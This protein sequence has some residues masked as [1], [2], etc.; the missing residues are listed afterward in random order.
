MSDIK[1]FIES[2]RSC[3]SKT[4]ILEQVSDSAND[5]QN[6]TE[7]NLYG[8]GAYCHYDQDGKLCCTEDQ[9]EYDDWG[10]QSYDIVGWD[11]HYQFECPYEQNSLFEE[12]GSKIRTN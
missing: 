10:T 11:Q 6:V 3:S 12:H 1:E 4:K 7:R 5:S 8:N 9:V 2:K